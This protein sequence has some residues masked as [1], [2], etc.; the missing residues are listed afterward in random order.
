MI[1]ATFGVWL[2]DT[3]GGNGRWLGDG[4]GNPWRG[5]EGDAAGY[6]ADRR[7]W[8]PH[9]VYTVR[10]VPPCPRCQGSGTLTDDP[11][12]GCPAGPS[13]YEARECPVCEGTGENMTETEKGTER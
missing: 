12:P 1:A 3:D 6:A 13:A 9:V 10:M 4:S 5:S 8:Y 11:L 7:G 2:T